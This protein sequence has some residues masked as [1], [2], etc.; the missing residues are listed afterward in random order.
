M[1]RDLRRQP[2]AGTRS[3]LCAW[4]RVAWCLLAFAFAG[5]AT[6]AAATTGRPTPP[7]VILIMADD[8]G[9]EALG[10]YGAADYRTPHLDRL[11]AEGLRFTHCHSQPLCTP[12]RVQLMTGKYNVRN[13]TTFGRLDPGER[14]FGHDLRALGYA[15]AIA[16]KW[17][18]G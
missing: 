8:L 4:R 18:L 2:R 17:Q 14:T 16:G 15:T 1:T 3:P 11:A 13:Y 5:R 6:A 12:S 10:S 7:N 9:A